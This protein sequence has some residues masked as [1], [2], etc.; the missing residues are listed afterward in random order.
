MTATTSCPLPLTVTLAPA[1]RWRDHVFLCVAR[2][3][4]GCALDARA[5]QNRF[6]AGAYCVLTWFLEGEVDLLSCAG[7][8]QK[9]RMARCVASGCQSQ[10][11]VSESCGD[12]H[13]FMVMVYPDAFHALF[14]I[15]LAHLQN[16]VVDVRS[17]L[18]AHGLAM[19]D[20]VFGADSDLTRQ[21]AVESFLAQHARPLPMTAWMRLRKARERLTLAVASA[22]FGVGPR[23]LQ[24][25]A[26]REAG[27]NLQTLTRLWRGERSF[28]H[29][30]RQHRLGRSVTLAAHA[31]DEGY[32]DQPHLIR[33]CKAHT[34]RTPTQLAQQMLTEEADW[35]YRLEFPAHEDDSP[36]R[37]A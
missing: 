20:A 5:R 36:S 22:M 21:Q 17:L 13:V 34:G 31:M 23:Q 25:L 12:V 29:A 33:E 11:L 3:T 16:R 37:S 26:L 4:R 14:G 9:I 7:Q 6:P 30:L 18:P 32:A 28:L 35:I 8:A 27:M 10:P 19:V 1:A 24:R 2:D 15:D